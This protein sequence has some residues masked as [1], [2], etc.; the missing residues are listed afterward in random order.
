[1][2][3]KGKLF[4]V[5]YERLQLWQWS[6]SGYQNGNPRLIFF[7]VDIHLRF[8]FATIVQL[9]VNSFFIRICAVV[10]CEFNEYFSDLPEIQGQNRR[11]WQNWDFSKKFLKECFEG[12]VSDS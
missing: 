3:S 2:E 8:S 6:L 12:E 9:C 4:P 1:M 10:S 7:L 11:Q 5:F